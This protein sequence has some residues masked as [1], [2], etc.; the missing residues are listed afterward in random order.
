[1]YFRTPFHLP[2]DGVINQ[3]YLRAHANHS[4]LE[5]ISSLVSHPA[6]SFPFNERYVSLL[7]HT[8][9]SPDLPESWWRQGENTNDPNEYVG[10]LIQIYSVLHDKNY[11]VLYLIE[12]T[13]HPIKKWKRIILTYHLSEESPITPHRVS[14]MDMSY[15]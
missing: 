8:F 14:E 6:E 9:R 12:S 7:T 3:Y 5:P 1:M 2:D 4:M 13:G 15:V 11:I 10:I